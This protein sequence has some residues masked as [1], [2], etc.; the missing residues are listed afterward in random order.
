[1]LRKII[2][3]LKYLNVFIINDYIIVKGKEDVKYDSLVSGSRVDSD[4][5]YSGGLRALRDP[6]HRPSQLLSH[7]RLQEFR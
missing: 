6:H 3:I 4:G 7:Q 5:V 2:P 1:M